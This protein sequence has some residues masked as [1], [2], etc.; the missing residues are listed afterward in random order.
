MSL[1]SESPMTTAFRGSSPAIAQA[2]RNRPGSGLP[3]VR[4]GSRP[5]ATHTAATIDPAPA[6]NPSGSGKTGSRLVAMNQAPPRATI[7][8]IES[9]W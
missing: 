7:D 9:R 6:C 2:S 3:I 1:C 5:L 4:S 8:A